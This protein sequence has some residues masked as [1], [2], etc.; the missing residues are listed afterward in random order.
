MSRG[1]TTT[2][3]PFLFSV[4]QEECQSRLRPVVLGGFLGGFVLGGSSDVAWP[5]PGLG[6]GRGWGRSG[7]RRSFVLPLTRFGRIK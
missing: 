4:I 7:E 5:I 6:R 1:N 3:R 2:F